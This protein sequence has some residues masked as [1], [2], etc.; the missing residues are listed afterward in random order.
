VIALGA[1]FSALE[2]VP[3]ALVGFEGLQTYRRIRAA[4]WV[5]SYRWPILCF[6]AVGFWNTVGAGLL[7]FAINPPASL[8]FVQ[9]LNLTPAHGHAALFGVYGMLG[10]GL[11]LFCLRGLYARSLHEDRLLSPAFWGLN[12]GLALMVFLSLV[13]AGIYQAVAS[14]TKG[15]WYARSPEVVHSAAMETL[16]WLRVPGD[17][18]FAI[19][20]LFLVVYLLKLL[21][22]RRAVT[23]GEAAEATRQAASS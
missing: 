22:R 14:I 1:V 9:G 11:M 3:L 18:L 17:I 6:V 21:G 16:V 4:P 12:S 20:A 13:P 19:G 7:G 8:Y 15:M 2:V 5:A 23:A 10:I